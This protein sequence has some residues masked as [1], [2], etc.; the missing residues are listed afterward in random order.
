MDKYGG[1]AEKYA[2]FKQYDYKAVSCCW[3]VQGRVR[4]LW[5][6]RRVL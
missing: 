1:G 2:R 6:H 3:R 5:W 4:G